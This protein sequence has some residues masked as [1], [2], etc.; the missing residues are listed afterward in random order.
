VGQAGGGGLRC[1]S[2]L[3]GGGAAADAVDGDFVF[4]VGG[5]HRGFNAPA[6]YPNPPRLGIS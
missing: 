5:D 3:G 6:Q 1:M 4:T 2:G